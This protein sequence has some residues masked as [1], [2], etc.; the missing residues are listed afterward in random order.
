[1]GAGAL[2]GGTAF[3]QFLA[4]L[5]LPALTRLYS[6][7]DFS[8]LAIYV[9][10]LTIVGAIICM[11]LDTAIPLADDDDEAGSLLLLAILSTLIVSILLSIV[12]LFYGST[13][14]KLLNRTEIAPYLWLLPVGAAL[15]GA[16]NALQYSALRYKS[17]RLIAYTRL[18]QAVAGVG[19]QIVLGLAALAP[20]GLLIGHVI[21][22]GSGIVPLARRVL[23]NSTGY[24]FTSIRQQ[25]L[26]TFQ[27]YRR[28]PQ[29]SVAEELANNAGIQLP[30]LLIGVGVIGPE[31]GYLFLAMRVIGM[32]LSV[33]G[34]A[35][36]QVYYAHITEYIKEGRLAEETVRI[37]LRLSIGIVTPLMFIGQLTPDIFRTLFGPEWERAGVLLVWMLPWYGFRL[38]VSPISMLMYARQLQ[39]VLLGFAM[40][41]LVLRVLPILVAIYMAP[42]W[43]SLAYAV[44]SAWYYMILLIAILFYAQIHIFR[45]IK[46]LLAS[47]VI[48]GAASISGVYIASLNF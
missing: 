25:L 7:E 34:G 46:V 10:I 15:T 13:F 11:R 42:E 45:V 2:A 16:Y 21:I 36:S 44:S 40:L 29:F 38:L 35:V 23:A 4:A 14:A 39:H 3:A 20:L 28:F 8:V 37:I 19:T 12:V 33:I 43:A 30:I 9:A 17:F 24:S 5:A 31:A 48:W 26:L 6:A 32:P 1:M 18:T 47:S 41:G 22:S 27:K